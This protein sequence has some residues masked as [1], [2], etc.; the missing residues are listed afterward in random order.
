MW[1]F[2]VVKSSIGPPVPIVPS[3]CVLLMVV[4]LF[5]GKSVVIDE[6]EV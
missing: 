2:D 4:T 6:L 1:P 5:S 3:T